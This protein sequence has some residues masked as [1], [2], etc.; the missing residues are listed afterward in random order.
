MLYYKHLSHTLDDILNELLSANISTRQKSKVQIT[1]KMNPKT[2]RVVVDDGTEIEYDLYDDGQPPEAPWLVLLHGMFWGVLVE[3]RRRPLPAASSRP[4]C[5]RFPLLR[6]SPP[7]PKGWSGSRRAFDRAIPYLTPHCRVLAPDLRHHG[8]SG[9]TPHGRH[10][11]RLAADLRDVLAALG[12]AGATLV[13][14]SMGS[15]VIWSYFELF[16]GARAVRLGG[17]VVVRQATGRICFQFA[18]CVPFVL[19]AFCAQTPCHHRHP[20]QQT[21]TPPPPPKITK[22]PRPCL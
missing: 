12:V 14:T 15:A 11:A 3:M 4:C 2:G 1:P 16:A 9:R 18:C 5:T 10:V 21:T 8:N 13:G 19:H 17:K 20:Q 22:R 7:L 6:L